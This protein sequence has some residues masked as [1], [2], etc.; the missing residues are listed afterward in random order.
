MDSRGNNT[1]ANQAI[2][3]VEPDVHEII[4]TAGPSATPNPAPSTAKAQM[5]LTA[6]DTLGHVLEYSWD[7]N[8][9]DG[10]SIGSFNDKFSPAPVF[11]ARSNSNENRTCSISVSVD[12]DSGGLSESRQFT[13]TV[14]PGTPDLSVTPAG[15]VHID[16][17]TDGEV[18]PSLIDFLLYNR[19][20]K[21][22]S[23]DLL[24]GQPWIIRDRSS[25]TVFPDS[26]NNA[27]FFF[28]PGNL[29]PDSYNGTITFD[30]GGSGQPFATV[31]VTM[32]VRD[33]T[34]CTAPTVTP[35]RNLT[36]EATGIFTNVNGDG[37]P[38]W[39]PDSPRPHSRPAASARSHDYLGC[40]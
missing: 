24:S 36:V 2:V 9:S 40:G 7:A 38:G 5:Q 19:G 39:P 13:L 17:T 8:C 22:A 14:L 32:T 31:A 30:D 15:R 26:T 35:P 10:L 25:R 33:A 12:D 28:V 11:S 23:V 21:I 3:I 1:I 37:P 27:L 6:I 4:F 18:F 29:A 20:N 34:G 16:A